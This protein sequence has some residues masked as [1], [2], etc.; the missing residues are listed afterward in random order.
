MLRDTRGWCG[1]SI[2]RVSDNLVLVIS[3]TESKVMPWEGFE[4]GE[5][6][7]AVLHAA[8]E[9]RG[10]FIEPTEILVGQ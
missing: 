7:D 8:Q 10:F 1:T 5:G 3:S 4:E 6:A 9:L 2:Q